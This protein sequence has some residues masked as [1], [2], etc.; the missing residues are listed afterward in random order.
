MVRNIILVCMLWF[1]CLAANSI[2]KAIEELAPK[3]CTHIEQIHDLQEIVKNQQEIL[4][5][6]NSSFDVLAQDLYDE[7]VMPKQLYELRKP[8]CSKN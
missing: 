8:K 5:T 3:E 6:L 7:T 1:F 2:I 4:M